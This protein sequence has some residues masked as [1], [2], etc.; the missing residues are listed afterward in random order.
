MIY[1][2]Q[3]SNTIH[4]VDNAQLEGAIIHKGH[5][6]GVQMVSLS[7]YALSAFCH[8]NE[9]DFSTYF[10]ACVIVIPHCSITNFNSPE[11]AKQGH[12]LY[13]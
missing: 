11:Q 7:D 10:N 9:F 13:I 4:F 12:S 5:K 8:R 3:S 6:Q 2:I 1:S